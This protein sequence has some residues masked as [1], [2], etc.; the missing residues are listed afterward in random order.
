MNTWK[1]LAADKPCWTKP[2]KERLLWGL[3]VLVEHNVHRSARRC[4]ATARHADESAS[5]LLLQRGRRGDLLA[6]SLAH[7]EGRQ[8]GS[9]VLPQAADESGG[10][11]LTGDHSAY[12]AVMAGGPRHAGSV[13]AVGETV[14]AG[15]GR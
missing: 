8:Q 13:G 1:P 15:V 10:V 7:R 9:T 5:A 4:S 11:R 6:I 12:D 3:Y 2:R 14:A